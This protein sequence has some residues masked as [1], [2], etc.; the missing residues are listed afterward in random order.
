MRLRAVAAEEQVRAMGAALVQIA[1]QEPGYGGPTEY[2]RGSYSC[3]VCEETSERIRSALAA[4][5]GPE[6]GEEA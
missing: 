5:P 3:D 6:P 2:G 1:N 4:V